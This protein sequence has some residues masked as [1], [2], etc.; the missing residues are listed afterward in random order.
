MRIVPAV[1]PLQGNVTLSNESVLD[2]AELTDD[3]GESDDEVL[4]PSEDEVATHILSGLWYLPK[5]CTVFELTHGVSAVQQMHDAESTLFSDTDY[6]VESQTDGIQ[7]EM[8]ED[9][10]DSLGEDSDNRQDDP[11]Y[12]DSDE[13]SD[14]W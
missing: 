1:T 9:W 12:I 7:A 8:G 11:N 4:G 2:E 13:E 10:R 6:E 14:Y 5:L 3:D